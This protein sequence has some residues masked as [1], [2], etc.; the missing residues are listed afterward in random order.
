MVCEVADDGPRTPTPPV[1][2]PGHVPP[3]PRAATGHGM[4][5]VRQLSDLVTEHIRPS[6][7]QVRLY[8]RD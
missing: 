3:Q 8:F 2:F 4:W 5:V 7:S 6:G 1:A